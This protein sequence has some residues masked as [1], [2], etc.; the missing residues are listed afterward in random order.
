MAMIGRVPRAARGFGKVERL[1][2]VLLLIGALIVWMAIGLHGTRVREYRN[3]G[4]LL[5]ATTTTELPG[6]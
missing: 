3:D 4:F 1:T 6:A 2:I 5:T